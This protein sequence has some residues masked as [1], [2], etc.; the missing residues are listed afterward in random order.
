[1]E[2]GRFA[3]GSG[4]AGANPSRLDPFSLPVRFTAADDGGQ[5]A[6]SR[7]RPASRARGAG[8]RSAASP[9]R[10]TCRSRPIARAIRLSGETG[11]APNSI[12][13]VL[14]H[15][16]PA[17]RCRCLPRRARRHSVRRMA[18]LGQGA[19]PAALGR[20]RRWLVARAVRPP[21]RVAH[22]SPN[23][24]PPPPQ[25]HRQAPSVSIAAPRARQA[26]ATPIVHRGEREIIARN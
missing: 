6:A 9:W 18:K 22:R 11:Q 16:D 26:A 7:S 17:C 23:L 20:R 24:A 14:E 8:A 25:R 10:S 21:R 2:A 15:R 12:A 5:R 13:V 3:A 19:R 1:M 4:R